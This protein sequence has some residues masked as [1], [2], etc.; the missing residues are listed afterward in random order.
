MST[1]GIGERRILFPQDQRRDGTLSLHGMSTTRG[2]EGGFSPEFLKANGL[3]MGG[4]G[5]PRFPPRCGGGCSP[6]FLGL[7]V[8]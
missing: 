8:R 6:L 5:P 3:S 1:T 2:G 7:R 4:E